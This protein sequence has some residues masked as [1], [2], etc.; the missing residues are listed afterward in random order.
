MLI[1]LTQQIGVNMVR[2][3]ET[4]GR[5]S[6]PRTPTTNGGDSVY[7]KAHQQSYRAGWKSTERVGKADDKTSG[8]GWEKGSQKST[9]RNTTKDGDGS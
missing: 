4:A 8:S 9:K 6:T 3:V 1:K 2:M 5:E 7:L